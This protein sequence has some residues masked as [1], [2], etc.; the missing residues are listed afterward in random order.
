MSSWFLLGKFCSVLWDC[1]FSLL[2]WLFNSKDLDFQGILRNGHLWCLATES[3]L[4][5]LLPWCLFC[6]SYAGLMVVRITKNFPTTPFIPKEP[7][8][9]NNHLQIDWYFHWFFSNS[10]VKVVG[11]SGFISLCLFRS[12]GKAMNL[13]CKCYTWPLKRGAQQRTSCASQC[14][15]GY[16]LTFYSK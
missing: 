16:P 12:L 6:K 15:F 10:Q 14:F 8:F 5:F 13:S 4:L 11:H 9:F 3:E 7:V 1:L 2:K